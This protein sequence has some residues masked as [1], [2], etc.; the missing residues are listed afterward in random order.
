VSLLPV[1]LLADTLRKPQF[2]R[3][4]MPNEFALELEGRAELEQLERLATNV[5]A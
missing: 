3:L 4:L 2:V 1:T 5:A